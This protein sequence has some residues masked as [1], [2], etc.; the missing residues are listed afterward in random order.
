MHA[1]TNNRKFTR[2]AVKSAVTIVISG[3][4]SIEGTLQNL[5]MGGLLVE[6]S[7][8]F[9]HGS[10]CAITIILRDTDQIAMRGMVV[11]VDD[12][13]MGIECT[14]ISKD[15]VKKIQDILVESADS[16]DDLLAEL[17]NMSHLVPDVY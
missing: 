7:E 9:A 17:S 1:Q 2:V 10:L 15:S 11:R 12:G 4:R 8:Q 6:A 14:G 5:A 3:D 13:S 16:S